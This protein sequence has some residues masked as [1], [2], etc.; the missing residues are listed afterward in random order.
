MP[1]RPRFRRQRFSLLRLILRALTFA[2]LLW[3]VGFAVFLVAVLLA[4][5]PNPMPLADG[6]VALTGGNARVDEALSLLEARNA[7]LLLISGAGPQTDLSAVTAKSADPPK[8]ALAADITLGHRAESTHGNAAEAAAWASQHHMHSLII[9]TADY[10]MP[11][12]L[13]ECQTAMPGVTLVADPVRPPAMHKFISVATLRLLA[14]E[15]S[16]YLVVRSGLGHAA[17]EFFFTPEP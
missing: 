17:A 14:A 3:S 12:A 1:K 7:P 11:R 16:K 10:H 2:V 6:I 4:G 9:V 13:L 8:R 5:P 15:Y